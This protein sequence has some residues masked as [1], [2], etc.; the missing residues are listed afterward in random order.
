MSRL[1]SPKMSTWESL[2]LKQQFLG[3]NLQ[4][5]V[6]LSITPRMR[7]NSISFFVEFFC[8]IP[9]SRNSFHFHNHNNATLGC[10]MSSYLTQANVWRLSKNMKPL[11]K[12]EF[13]EWWLKVE[14]SLFWHIQEVEHP[15]LICYGL[16]I[17]SLK[18]PN[19]KTA[20][21]ALTDLAF[22]KAHHIFRM[23]S[24]G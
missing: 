7:T 9:S 23:A 21:W 18:C 2:W 1:K 4:Y 22:L 14:H 3:R 19:C 6:R 13:K 15:T 10:Q 17:T 16:I 24:K 20:P 8:S 12:K 11:S 5:H